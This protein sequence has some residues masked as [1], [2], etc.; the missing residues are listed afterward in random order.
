MDQHDLV[1]SI[2][3][4]SDYKTVKIISNTHILANDIHR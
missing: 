4:N 1:Y 2:M 3:L